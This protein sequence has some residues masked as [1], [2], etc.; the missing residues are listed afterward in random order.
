MANTDDFKRM[1][2]L[3]IDCIWRDT[4]RPRSAVVYMFENLK[5]SKVYVGTTVDVKVRLADHIR[6]VAN[7]EDNHFYRAIKKYGWD[8]FEFFILESGLT[9]KEGYVME[10][11]WIKYLDSFHNGYNST[12]GGEGFS[13]GEYHARTQKIKGL[14]LN[15]KEEFHWDWIGG[16]AEHLGVESNMICVA[17]CDSH[18]M[19]QAYNW[20]K[21]ER[22]IFKYE[23][24]DT[25]WDD[26]IKIRKLP[27]IVRNIDTKE[28]LLF[29]SI[30]DAE[31]HLNIDRRNISS[32]LIGKCN[33]FY[34]NSKNNRYEAQ[35]DPP[36]R[37]WNDNIPRCEDLHNKPIHAYI[38]NEFFSWYKSSA[39]AGKHLN[40]PGS[41]ISSSARHERRS[42]KSGVYTFEF[43]DPI[44]REKQPPRPEK[45][46]VF[47]IKNGEKIL[48]D[49][50]S[51]A[52]RSTHDVYSLPSRMRHIT[53]SI[54]SQL[55]DHQG[56]QWFKS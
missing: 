3:E 55:P 44:L 52:A 7:D 5:T 18:E 20:D 56:I 16:A 50:V 22:W 34:S 28:L 24:D 30:V 43:A 46:Y 12:L 9:Q 49:S 39:E 31:R 40:L 29:E 42:D 15:T 13:A 27:I 41:A 35:Y 53:K 14:N 2:S 37:E 33:Q 54:K 23:D 1:F 38:N 47:Y 19:K 21:T 26:W 48:F 10:K 51:C 4:K 32:V 36:D 6:S 45:V 25:P 8:S 17:L 11:K